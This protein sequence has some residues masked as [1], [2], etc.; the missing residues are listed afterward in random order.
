MCY[1]KIKNVTANMLSDV[2]KN[3]KLEPSLLK[4]NR[5]TET[6]TKTATKKIRLT[7]SHMVF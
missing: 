5:K 4:R 2:Y 1:N 3:V 7:F 6:I